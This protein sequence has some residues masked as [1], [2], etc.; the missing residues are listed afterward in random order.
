MWIK[1]K[2]QT[3]NSGKIRLNSNSGKVKKKVKFKLII[4][5]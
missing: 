1:N 5:N 3:L 4:L 2:K